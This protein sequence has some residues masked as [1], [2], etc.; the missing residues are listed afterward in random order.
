MRTIIDSNPDFVLRLL[1]YTKHLYLGN[2]ISI[3]ET[4][5]IL[6]GFPALTSLSCLIGTL[7]QFSCIIEE[8]RIRHASF[9]IAW[10][11]DIS[12][13]PNSPLSSTLTHLEILSM[14]QSM[15]K[16]DR[17]TR[18]THLAVPYDWLRIGWVGI[19]LD[20]CKELRVLVVHSCVNEAEPLILWSIY[21]CRVVT[22]DYTTD[23]KHWEESWRNENG[24][25][26]HAEAVI[27]RR[28]RGRGRHWTNAE[29]VHLKR[30]RKPTGEPESVVVELCPYGC[31]TVHR[32]RR[33]S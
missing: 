9:A 15:P 24:I 4:T 16:L 2:S 20:S 32:Q 7:E 5:N 1:R 21:D 13:T 33:H 12:L 22:I 10:G 6:S 28:E 29:R 27:S 25:W 14:P 3:K 23:P 26:G 31:D 19:T 8:L 17:L 30:W 18:L 11:L